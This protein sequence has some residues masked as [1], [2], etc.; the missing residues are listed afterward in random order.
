MVILR[1]SKGRKTTT[2]ALSINNITHLI[3]IAAMAEIDSN[4]KTG[5]FTLSIKDLVTLI[6]M[7]SSVVNEELLGTSKL[8]LTNLCYFNT[9][10][11]KSVK[12][13]VEPSVDTVKIRCVDEELIVMHYDHSMADTV[14]IRCVAEELIVMHYDHSMARTSSWT[15]LNV[16]MINPSPVGK[17]TN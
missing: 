11:G 6:V 7:E 5:Q 4:T 14:K 9:Y 13:V 15:L 8:S 1:T 17:K 12:Y 10:T 2:I 16:N 3:K